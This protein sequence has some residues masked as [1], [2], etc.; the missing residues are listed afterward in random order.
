[1][2][3]K[4]GICQSWH[5]PTARVAQPEGMIDGFDD[6]QPF[7]GD[8]EP[9]GERPAFGVAAAQQGPRQGARAISGQITLERHHTPLQ[10]LDGPCIVARVI[11]GTPQA[12]LRLRLEAHMPQCCRQGQRALAVVDGAGHIARIPEIAAYKGV[13]PPKA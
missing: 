3:H 5:N 4:S 9:L 13:D 10:T 8:G 7:C 11:I 1:M 2:G 6:P 12:V